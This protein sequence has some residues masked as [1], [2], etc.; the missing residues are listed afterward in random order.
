MIARF[1]HE[2]EEKTM[3]IFCLLALVGVAFVGNQIAINGALEHWTLR[4]EFFLGE[5]VGA[6]VGVLAYIVMQP[7][8]DEK[9]F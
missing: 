7:Q 4:G 5:V 1:V 3:R 6:L 2:S 8:S 9:R